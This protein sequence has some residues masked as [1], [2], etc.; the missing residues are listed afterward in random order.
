MVITLT[1][2]DIGN[3]SVNR[4]ETT[5]ANGEYTFSN[6]NPGTY[7][8][9]RAALPAGAQNGPVNVGTGATGSTA[10]TTAI[11]TITLG[12]AP[13]AAEFNF[14]ALLSPLSKRRFLASSSST[15]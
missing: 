1:G 6:V 10:G 13:A 15:D 7:T 8:L 3:A 11:S 4:T 5:D 9:T 12:N 2:A 14:G